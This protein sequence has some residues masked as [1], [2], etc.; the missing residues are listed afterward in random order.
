MINLEEWLTANGLEQCFPLFAGHDIDFEVLADLTEVDMEKL[1]LSFGHRRKLLRALEARRI[2]SR[3]KPHPG[4]PEPAAAAAPTQV[5]ERRQIT[6]M[7]CDLVGSTELANLLDPEI[8]RKLIGQYQDLCAGA[9]SRYQGYVAKFMGD[10]VLAYFGYPNANE[11]AAEHAVRSAIAI[12]ETVAQ[13]KHPDGREFQV[14]VGIATGT[15]V[16]G[17]VIGMGSAREHGIV[18]ETPNLAARLQ[19]L[20]EPNAILIS[21]NTHHLL[22]RRFE[23][24][25]L[26]DR[27]I[28]GFAAPVH[29][30]Q[31]L[32]E[33]VVERRFAVTR[34]A[35]SGAFV[36]RNEETALLFERWRRATQGE[37]SALLVSGEAGMGKSRLVD[38]LFEHIADQ[39]CYH[40]TCQ[41]SPY[42]T[43]SALYP[44][45]RHLERAAE[46][47]LDDC[48]SVKLEKLDAML[49]K[50]T[51]GTATAAASLIADLLTLPT[52]RY[53]KLELSPVQRKAETIAALVDLLTGLA[54]DAPVLLLLEDAHW[55]DPTSRELWT[56]LIDS[57][58]STR[59]LALIS[60][61]PEFVSPWADRAQ[62]SSLGITR[63]TGAQSAEL[64][65]DIAAPRVL[66]SAIVDDIV[67]KS[68]GVPLFVEELTKT[69]LES[70]SPDRP[71]VPT[72][73]QDSLMARLDRLGPAREI[74]QV[75]AVIGQ[76]FSHALLAAVASYSAAE[77]AAGILRLIEAGLAYRQT[78]A[79]ESGYSF[80][81][82]LLRDVAYENLLRARRQELHERIGRVLMANFAAI[83][84]VEPE[85]LAHHFHHAELFDLACTYRERAGDRAIAR[86]SFTEGI[87][88]FKA[89]LAEAEKLEDPRERAQREL[90]LLLKLGPPVGIVMGPGNP[91]A[92]DLYRRALE[93]ATSVGGENERFRAT[94]GLW[95]NANVGRRLDR[96]RVHADELMLHGRQSGDGDLILE[97]FHCLWSTAWF[98]GEIPTARLACEEG[99]QRYDRAKHSWMGPVYGGHDPGVCAFCVQAS[100]WSAQ[101]RQ[102][103][104]ARCLDQ[105]ITLAN[106][107]GMIGSRIHA[108]HNAVVVAQMG[109]DAAS[110]SDYAHRL[111]EM[112]Q[113]YNIPP[114]RAH[115]AFLLGWQQAN[116]GDLDGGL[117]IMEAEYPRAS[118]A[119]PFMRY[120]AGLLAEGRAKS[121]RYA[122]ALELIGSALQ[123]VTEPGVG[124]YVS[125]LHRLRG[126]CLIR[127]S[128][129]HAAEAMDAHR[130]ALDIAAGQG[131]TLLELR[132]AVSLSHTAIALGRPTEG[133]VPLRD[134]CAK[135]PEEFQSDSLPEARDLL[136]G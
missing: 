101:G 16:I 129:A 87:A 42:H 119:G 29:V 96:A 100:I 115:A 6:V 15:V 108:L 86:S 81:H 7:F 43:N 135:L 125:E 79:T 85:L 76:Q 61:R 123:T 27:S 82:A 93:L 75:A 90:G 39:P 95:L 128:P 48:D 83:A 12:V 17:D 107:I 102:D 121:R 18:G 116:A 58:A 77:L 92:E 78:R 21:S 126:I 25:S 133:L 99:I 88:H 9:I 97:G 33:A 24:D 106:E 110:L 55:I 57:I 46:F 51:T 52:D 32:R 47:A 131:A 23:Y 4:E 66:A 114:Q 113:K 111:L 127:S 64:V 94:W 109:H 11:H 14:R 71:T 84:E 89:A 73:L 38:M 62:F 34:N 1:G 98:R 80:R 103:D 13:L 50:A 122:E 40:V 30:W 72:S 117:A 22:G 69:V 36:G 136:V 2:E 104:A 65:A 130:T 10:G 45:I 54:D 3:P 118:A 74:A 37:G 124:F 44:V 60:A 112:A 26:G 105:G 56:R 134:L 70:D 68:D 5:A 28:K 59:L 132:A 120:Y 63:L 49:R 53:P 41:C 8:V 31:V 67:A 19:S 20:A 91:A 35:N